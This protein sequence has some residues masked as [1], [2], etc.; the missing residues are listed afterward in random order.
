MH[1]VL[2]DPTEEI[3][4]LLIDNLYSTDPSAYSITHLY[5]RTKKKDIL[6]ALP[7][8]DI[9]IFGYRLREQTVLQM[10]SLIRSQG[11]STPIFVLTK[12]YNAGV[13]QKY[14]KAGVDERLSVNELKSPLLSWTLMSSMRMA[15]VRKKAGDFDTLKNRLLTLSE[16]LAYI[17]HEINNPLSVMRLALYHLQSYQLDDGR[18]DMLM[19]ILSENIDKV[20]LQM[21]ELR[22]VRRQMGGK[23]GSE[24]IPLPQKTAAAQG[25]G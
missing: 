3:K 13:P 9:V 10:T 18:R 5:P 17:T 6:G 8:A 22:S 12:E 2:F 23:V 1:I 16:T 15:E 4:S 25:K 14:K 7:G 11:H 21:D 19:K 20:Q 24:C